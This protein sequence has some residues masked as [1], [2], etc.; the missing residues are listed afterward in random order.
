MERNLK[1]FL[2]AALMVGA[3]VVGTCYHNKQVAGWKQK[4]AASDSL[5]AAERGRTDSL[6]SVV[7]QHDSLVAEQREASD[8]AI[9]Q[10]EEAIAE[11][12]QGNRIIDATVQQVRAE[13]ATVPLQPRARALVDHLSAAYEQMV[14]NLNVVV[15]RKD[16]IISEKNRQI[17]LLEVQIHNR[18][19]LI[20][21]LNV[22]KHTLTT[23]VAFWQNEAK[24]GLFDG[25]GG[26]ALGLAAAFVAG[27]VVGSR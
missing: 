8:A 2:L 19:E 24:P 18:D 21:Q 27:V 16:S 9:E 12:E 1:A 15:A 22:E 6:T 3:L 4:V 11:R 26:K 20:A 7:L 17:N 23:Q 13:L 5:L 10:H 14:S 25:M